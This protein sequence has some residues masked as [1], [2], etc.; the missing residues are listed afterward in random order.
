MKLDWLAPDL[1]P[2]IEKA[3]DVQMVALILYGEARSE[4]VQ[5]IVAVGSV[6]RNR[7]NTDL[8]NDKKPDWWG[9]GYKGVCA[10]SWQFSCLHPKGGEGN[11]TR[12]RDFAE[13]LISGQPITAANER[14]CIWVAHGIVGNYAIDPTKG[15]NHY[16]TATMTPRPTWAKGH[17]PAV[18]VGGHSFYATVT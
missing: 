12:V 6:I 18:Q 2:F 15:S 17:T 16:H 13:R 3:T 14:Q 10:Q 11:Y 7:V 4:P 8:H 5:G 9:E 1:R